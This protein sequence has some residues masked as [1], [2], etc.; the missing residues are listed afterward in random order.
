MRLQQNEQSKFQNVAHVHL[1]I[2]G[3]MSNQLCQSLIGSNKLTQ[4]SLTLQSGD[5]IK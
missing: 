3:K 2:Y 1:P 5:K 4:N